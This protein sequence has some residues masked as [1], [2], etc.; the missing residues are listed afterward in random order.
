MLVSLVLETL[1]WRLLLR[2]VDEE[3][4]LPKL[5]R[6]SGEG[7]LSMLDELGLLLLPSVSKVLL[8]WCERV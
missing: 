6:P 7:E 3:L 4:S 5:T 1:A 8:L 2:C